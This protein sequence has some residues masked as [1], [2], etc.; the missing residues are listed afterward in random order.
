MTRR[1][2]QVALLQIRLFERLVG[3]NPLG[4]SDLM[5]GIWFRSRSKAA[6]HSRTP[7]PRGD[8]RALLNPTGFGVRL[9]SAALDCCVLF[10]QG[11]HTHSSPVLMP[12]ELEKAMTKQEMADLLAFLKAE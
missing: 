1:L 4:L 10:E 6:E 9:C 11:Y 3:R 7:K 2:F 12:Q 8:S 5:P